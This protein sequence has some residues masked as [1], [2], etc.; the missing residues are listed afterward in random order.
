MLEL[1]LAGG[2]FTVLEQR[3]I[4]TRIFSGFPEPAAAAS[5]ATNKQRAKYI[6]GHSN[7]RACSHRNAP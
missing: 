2:A 5:R 7:D 4:P 1:M 3:R 6:A